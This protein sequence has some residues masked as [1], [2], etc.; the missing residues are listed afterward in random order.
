M[1]RLVPGRW[2]LMRRSEAV[3]FVKAEKS[4]P[5]QNQRVGHLPQASGPPSCAHAHDG[6]TRATAM[7]GKSLFGECGG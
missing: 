1:G 7:R 4:L 3:G 6:K 5:L 2:R